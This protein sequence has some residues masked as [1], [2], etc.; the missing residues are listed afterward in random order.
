[1]EKIQLV[2]T[3]LCPPG[4]NINHNLAS[5]AVNAVAIITDK[6]WQELVKGLIKQAHKRVNLP[7][8]HTCITD[9]LREN[10][11]MPFENHHYNIAEFVKEASDLSDKKA[12]IIIKMGFRG[13]YALMPD[14]TGEYLL[15][16]SKAGLPSYISNCVIDEAWLY[17][18]GIDFKTG[19][20]R[21]S[22]IHRKEPKINDKLKYENMNPADKNIGDCVIR[23]LSAAYKCTWHEAI[24]Y[25]A[26]ANDYTDPV[27]NSIPNINLA[28][29]KL[30]FERHREI[31]RANKFLTGKQFCDLMNHTYHDGER[32]FAYVGK[33]HCAAI[34]PFEENGST[35]YK[36]QDTWDSTSRTVREYWVYKEKKPIQSKARY[37]QIDSLNINDTI[38]H[39]HF[40]KGII[41]SEQKS[42]ESRILEI[43]FEKAGVKK[44][45]E[46][47]LRKFIDK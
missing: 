3:V 26:Q 39:P 10:G 46:E 36:I 37:T 41:I 9:M 35:V 28:L 13:Y 45:S 32:I 25:I 38:T 22:N 27:L 34:L 1:M 6:S 24:D 44:I 7:T 15:K 21:K 12:K 5:S 33:S 4:I 31:K 47:W 18:E 11:F 19:I 30:G 16:G 20:Y 23:G 42:G 17:C 14:D 29:L 2:E 8:Y 40:G 43:D